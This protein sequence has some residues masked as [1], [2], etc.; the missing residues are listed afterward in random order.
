[1]AMSSEMNPVE[2]DEGLRRAIEAAGGVRALARA[3]GIAHESLI[4]WK[5]VPADRILKVE[6]VTGVPRETLRPDL[7]RRDSCDLTTAC[8][9][10][11]REPPHRHPDRPQ[12]ADATKRRVFIS[13]SQEDREFADQLKA[14]LNTRGFYRVVYRDG[15][16]GGKDWKRR[17]SPL[18]AEADAVVL[19]LSPAS[20]KSKVCNWEVDESKRLGKRIL[21]V[22]CRAIG[23]ERRPASL[24][25]INYFL[26]YHDPKTP[27]S[28][29]GEGLKRL[30]E[31]LNYGLTGLPD[32]W[33]QEVLVK[34]P[35]RPRPQ[36]SRNAGS[37]DM[38]V[39]NSTVTPEKALKEA[40]RR[41]G[42]P[43][44]LAR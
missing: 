38:L 19:A 33:S 24:P 31:A 37:Q 15:I 25:A 41:A 5:R 9:E 8:S 39:T 12:T 28:G 3:L 30:V 29:F 35:K 13:Y 11:D 23:E 18:I 22:I 36:T 26:F 43:G 16:S 6:A 20:V 40:I 21:P 14:A 27:G 7:Y 42:G 2:R 1:M 17:A 44:A 10:G 34:L 32:T 4:Q